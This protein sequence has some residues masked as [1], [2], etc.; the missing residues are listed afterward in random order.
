MCAH[1]A[2]PGWPA[3]CNDCIGMQK[4]LDKGGIAKS[5][6]WPCRCSHGQVFTTATAQGL[7]A[8]NVRGLKALILSKFMFVVHL[9][10]FQQPVIQKSLV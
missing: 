3:D 6:L 2:H 7:Q 1:S 9:T 8:H 5:N 10:K 4:Q